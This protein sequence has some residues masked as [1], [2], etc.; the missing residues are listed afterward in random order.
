MLLFIFILRE[1]RDWNWLDLV[2]LGP[3]TEL[4]ID[5]SVVSMEHEP[6]QFFIRPVRIVGFVYSGSLGVLRFFGAV[7]SVVVAKTNGLASTGPN[8]LLLS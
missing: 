1:H 7:E 4:R 3:Y 8:I 6:L 2:G 5:I